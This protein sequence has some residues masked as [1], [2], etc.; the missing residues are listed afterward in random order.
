MRI[1]GL[2]LGLVA[3]PVAAE[4]THLGSYVLAQDDPRFGGFSG[5]EVSGN[6]NA[7]VAITDRGFIING[8]FSRS[9]DT[10]EQMILGALRPLRLPDGGDVTAFLGDSEGLAMGPNG[11][12][13]IS[14]EGWTRV[15]AETPD[16]TPLPRLP[17]HPDFAGMQGNGSLEAL[18]IDA[19][20]TL[21]AIPERSG[22]ALRPFPVY[23]LTPGAAQWQ[24]AFHIPRI[25]QMVPVGADIGPDG[26]LYLLERDFNGLAFSSRI[27]RI[28][29]DGT[30][31][32]VLLQT[33]PGAH[34]NLEGIAVW[35]DDT[36]LRLT[37]ISD[38][39]FRWFQRTEIVE[40]RL[41]H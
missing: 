14:Y 40:Y 20:G 41:T 1:L 34:D 35:A 30:G 10:I 27:R 9:A 38:D 7:F 13:V 29:L 18:A 33:H 26:M 12:R 24:V 32:E 6:G 23:R 39:N 2:L 8:Q 4:M 31:G 21:F 11:N 16:G 22:R 37:L 17:D 15:R 3:G 5:I 28:A 36:G 25:G 19:G